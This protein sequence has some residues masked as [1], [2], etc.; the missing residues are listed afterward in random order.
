MLRLVL[1][2]AHQFKIFAHQFRKHAHACLLTQDQYRDVSNVCFMAVTRA[3]TYFPMQDQHRDMWLS[4][5]RDA[6]RTLDS[7]KD[8]VLRPGELLSAL[9]KSLP[10]EFEEKRVL[11]KYV[12]GAIAPCGLDPG[13]RYGWECL[14]LG[15]F[16]STLA[17]PRPSDTQDYQTDRAAKCVC[18]HSMGQL[19]LM[20]QFQN[21]FSPSFAL[22]M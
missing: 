5:A 22:R 20:R 9:A 17:K 12:P 15:K 18:L 3:H 16:L 2:F 7:D 8:G 6:F 19:H 10:G 21:S 13:S 14:C 4:L 11:T 1:L